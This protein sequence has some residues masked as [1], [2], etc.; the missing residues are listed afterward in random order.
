MIRCYSENRARAA[1]AIA[2]TPVS[3]VGWMTGAK[4]GEWLVGMSWA[5]R[6]TDAFRHLE[7]RQ[8]REDY[9]EDHRE[10]AGQ[11]PLNLDL[12]PQR[13]SHGDLRDP[14]KHASF[15][16]RTLRASG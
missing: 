7:T 12:A 8:D 15:P 14:G 10:G 2:T 13:D 16:G 1:T 5:T 4:L 6:L 11:A 9:P 3:S